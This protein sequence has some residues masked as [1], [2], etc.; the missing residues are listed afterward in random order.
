MAE[1]P[2]HRDREELL[3]HFV[4]APEQAHPILRFDFAFEHGGADEDSLPVLAECL[5][6]RT[7]VELPHDARGDAVA[8]EPALQSSSER[9]VM[10]RHQDRHTREIFWESASAAPRE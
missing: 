5:H 1:A 4:D 2:L 8:I 7:V 9:G 3:A 10:A 6:Q